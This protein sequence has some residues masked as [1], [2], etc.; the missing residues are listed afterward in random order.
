MDNVLTIEQRPP[1]ISTDSWL[2][3]LGQ[4]LVGWGGLQPAMAA[5][6]DKL[7]AQLPCQK[8]AIGL[9][10]R[11]GR[12]CR[13]Q[14]VS[15][16][17]RFDR[18][19]EMAQC[20]EAVFDESILKGAVDVWPDAEG[21]QRTGT[22]AQRRLC[23]LTGAGSLVSAPL[24]DAEGKT[25]GAWVFLSESSLADEAD[26]L[27]LIEAAGP[28]AGK[29]LALL[30][31]A[32]PGPLRR[33][34]RRRAIGRWT[35]FGGLVKV[36]V[37]A[38]VAALLAVPRPYKVKCDCLLQPVT[39]RFVAAPFDAK[40]EEALV[41]PGDLVGEDD[42]L[43]RLDGREIRWELAGL[44]ADYNRA[45]KLR[46]TGLVGRQVSEAQMAA[47]EME[48]LKLRIRL[49]ENRLKGLQ[50][51]APVDGLVIT[52]DLEKTE[53]A[54]LAKGQV[55]F[56]IAPL[57]KMVVELA[58]PDEEISHVQAGQQ[59]KVRLDAHPSLTLEG[60]LARIHPR[61]EQ[62]DSQ[63]VFIGEVLLQNPDRVLRPGMNGRA[64]IVTAEHPLGWNLFHKAYQ[65][66][67]YRLGW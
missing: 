11:K 43:A 56:E 58:I 41:E 5:V 38:S 19:S 61:A 21:T 2:L 51:K 9:C 46:D 63:N 39:R 23:E 15:G 55:L 18:R 35:G 54:P 62:R 30:R 37:V 49:F 13:L 3:Q 57:G 52:G 4:T 29:C 14:A 47:L 59:V 7:V 28:Y 48:R 65:H 8:V 67:V 60:T 45:K 50:I 34:A 20:I 24:C 25:L 53:G 66:V 31:R 22:V 26:K 42:L 16:A 36:L 40:L 10:R 44:T 12:H 27:G 6:A 17:A 64:G 33:W 1:S 32:E